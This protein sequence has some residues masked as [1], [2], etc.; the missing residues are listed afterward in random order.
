MKNNI[1]IG[2]H[3]S[4][5]GK[6][7]FLGAAQ[8]AA[9]YNSTCFMAY[10]GA[11]QNSRRKPIEELRLDEMKEFNKAYDIR[12][13]VI[14]APYIINLANNKTVDLLKV[15]IDRSD[16]IGASTLV[17]HPG[18]HVSLTR[19][20][21]L[22]NIIDNLNETLSASQNVILCL[23]TMAGKGSELGTTFEEIKQIID[24][25]ILKDKIGVCL[26]TCHIWDAGYDIVNDWDKIIDH[27]DEVI[28]LDKLKVIHLNDSKNELGA[29]KDRHANIGDGFIGFE[30]L[31]K[32]VHD[33]RLVHIPKILETPYIDKKPPYKNEIEMLT[34]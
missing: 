13:I 21:G 31:H 16:A 32:I 34:K 7:M 2:S 9:S 28:G 8:E 3:V 4:A 1:L 25:V 17:L 12:E 26:D 15:E 18:A 20:Q 5:S 27:F 6:P 10:T 24:G 33:E 30:T 29:H 11:P 19:E 22:Q 14:H 23:E